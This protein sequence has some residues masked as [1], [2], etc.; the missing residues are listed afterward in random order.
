MSSIAYKI[1][2]ETRPGRWLI[3]C[4][5]ASNHVPAW[6]NGGNNGGDLGLPQADMV[7]HIAFDPGAAGLTLALAEALD[8][9]AITS[10]F[11]RLVIDPNRGADDP[12][13]LRKLSDGAIIPA[14]R[15]AD[16]AELAL[17]LDRLYRPYHAAYGKLAARPGTVVCGVHTFSPQMLGRAPRP[18]HIGI[19]YADQDRRLAGPLIDRLRGENDLRIG[20]NQPY[21]GHFPGDSLDQHALSHGRPNLLI[22]LRNDLIETP[23]HQAA[24]AARLAPMLTDTLKGTGL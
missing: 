17:R 3:A 23:Q 5:H 9:P 11:S 21:Y 13:L 4:D 20:D 12:T 24:W 16:E 7:R 22:E 8:S 2:G 18:W 1:I 15:D 6:V 14:N 10:N 19:L